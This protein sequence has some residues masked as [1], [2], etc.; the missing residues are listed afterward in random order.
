MKVRAEARSP[1]SS[2]LTLTAG[3]PAARHLSATAPSL[4]R[5]RA[6]SSSRAPARAKAIALAAPIP[7]EAPVTTTTAP[8]RR[9]WLAYGGPENRLT[10]T[11]ALTFQAEGDG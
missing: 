1:T 5:R 9:I 8:L 4:S 11:R 6:P 3:E 7:L 10:A 2:S